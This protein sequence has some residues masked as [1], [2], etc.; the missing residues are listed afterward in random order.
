MI[1]GQAQCLLL[2][3]WGSIKSIIVKIKTFFDSYAAAPLALRASATVALSTSQS[4]A[5]WSLLTVS[6]DPLAIPK[7]HKS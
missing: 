4:I 6:F 2:Q 3:G 7:S 5:M 1:H